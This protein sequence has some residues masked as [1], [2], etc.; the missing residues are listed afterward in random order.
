MMK[1][2]TSRRQFLIGA[3]S[4]GAGVT[5]LPRV[6]AGSYRANEKVGVALVGVSG[7]GSWFVSLLAR[8]NPI[9]RG[10]ALCDVNTERAAEAYRKFPDLPKYQDF[11][12]MLDKQ[13]D[14]EGVIVATPEFSRALIM[15]AAMK[16]NKHVFGEKPL[17]REPY[18]SRVMRQLAQQHKVATQ[19]GNQGSSRT[20]F[21]QAKTL[22]Q[23]GLLGDIKEVH[24]WHNGS[25]PRG[26]GPPKGGPDLVPLVGSQPVPVSLNWDLWLAGATQRQYNEQWYKWKRWR[27]FFTSGLGW[28]APHSAALTFMACNI[29][30]LWD[31]TDLP[32]GK[33]SI[34]IVPT[35]PAVYTVGFPRW[36]VVRYEVPARGKLPAMTYTW[37]RGTSHLI[38]KALSGYPQWKDK[39]PKPWWTHGGSAFVGPKGTLDATHYGDKWQ[40]YPSELAESE[41]LKE[42]PRSP[43]HERQWLESIRGKGETASDFSVS[44]PLNEFLMLG[45]V[46]T[47]I[48][49]P[50]TYDPVT[51]NV[52]DNDAAQAA[53]HQEYRQGW[54]L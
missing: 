53:L 14:I 1:R 18:E 42:V 27:D 4:I 6:N 44:G 43:G 26:D 45:N 54:T 8:D 17:T 52:L 29:A 36:E 16:A 35:V 33:R 30:E 25:E 2:Y 5:V 21:Q 13:K 34:R 50:F 32:V 22:V 23:A 38:E 24:V 46:A 3:A 20:A 9:M 10:A 12:V 37:H 31:A 48:G 39:R 47:L 15:A 11:R 41:L 7:R 49:R 19:M 51:G 40:V 28:A